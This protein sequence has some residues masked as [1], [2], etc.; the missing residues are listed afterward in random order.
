[1]LFLVRMAGCLQ[2]YDLVL[3]KS[4]SGNKGAMRSY[5]AFMGPRLAEMHRL[6]KDT[7]SIYLHCDPTASHYLK[8]VMDAIWDQS[9][10][11][12]NEFFRNEIVWQ[13]THAHSDGKQYG[14]IHDISYNFGK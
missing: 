2:G 14:R 11:S 8:G 4:V 9:N 1:M 12:E 6:L 10:Y 3:Q 7:G 13:R 5:L